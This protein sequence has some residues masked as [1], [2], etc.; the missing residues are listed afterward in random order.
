MP[1]KIRSPLLMRAL[2]LFV[3]LLL[4]SG[5]QSQL[6]QTGVFKA[7]MSALQKGLPLSF[8]WALTHLG[9]TPWALGFCIPWFYVQPRLLLAWGLAAG[10]GG[11]LSVSLKEGFNVLRPAALL[12]LQGLPHLGPWLYYNSFPS[13]HTITIFATVCILLMRQH[14]IE[15]SLSQSGRVSRDSYKGFSLR[16]VT[17][18]KAI[19]KWG[20]ISLALLVGLSRIALGAHWPLDVL[21]GA[22]VG[23]IAACLGIWGVVSLSRKVAP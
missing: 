16:K 12:D 23:G 3:C 10:V 20:L 19:M 15:P 8:W 17:L 2:R 4:M 6:D 1:S 9:E 11:L 7:L 22:C 18:L 13:G 14:L 5:W 21:A